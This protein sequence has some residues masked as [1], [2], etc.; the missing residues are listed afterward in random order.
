[1]MVTPRE[2]DLL[3]DRAA[4]LLAMTVHAAL[5][6]AYSPLELLAVAR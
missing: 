3:I 5:Q 6:P 4:R 1:M 2:I